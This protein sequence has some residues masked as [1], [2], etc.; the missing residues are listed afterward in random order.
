MMKLYGT[1]RILRFAGRSV[2]IE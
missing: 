2:G 1:L